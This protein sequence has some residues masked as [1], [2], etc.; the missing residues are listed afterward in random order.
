M[1]RGM[2]RGI[3]SMEEKHDRLTIRK[4]KWRKNRRQG[5]HF[6]DRRRERKRER[7]REREYVF[8]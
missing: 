6:K 7:E 8:F 5:L 1:T 3:T 4:I 2:K